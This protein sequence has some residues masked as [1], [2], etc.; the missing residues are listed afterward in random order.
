MATRTHTVASGSSNPVIPRRRMDFAFDPTQVPKSYYAN[1]PFLTEIMNAL[2]TLF[3]EGE[4]FFVDSVRHYKDQIQ[5]PVLQAE[6]VGF[7]GQEAM[8]SKEHEAFNAMLEAH[9]NP[10]AKKSDAELEVL[11]K[12]VRKVLSPASQLAATCALEHYTAILAEQILRDEKH[13]EAL[14][15]TMQPLWL[16]HALE[17]NEHKTVAY[18]VYETVDGSYLR[19]TS[20]MLLATVV[21]FAVAT[22]VWLRMVAAR[23]KL[24]DVV[25]LAKAVD[26]LWLRRGLF[27]SLIPAYLDYFRPGFH[28]NDHD[29]RAL[30]DDWREKLF[31]E[32]G[33]MKAQLKNVFVPKVQSPAAA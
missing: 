5:D 3:P 2:S 16:W 33:T 29:T 21:F 13:R 4:Q 17:E 7:V 22:Q 18:D 28:P 12:L 19:R 26:Y 27:R 8:H 11:L 15:P 10:V 6:I 1:D 32:S 24:G 20:I 9:G 23:G 31:G 30:L 14:H 25:G